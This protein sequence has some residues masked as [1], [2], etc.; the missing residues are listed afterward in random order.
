MSIPAA[1]RIFGYI[2]NW[3]YMVQPHNY[4]KVLIV[5]QLIT[6]LVLNLLH[7]TNNLGAVCAV[8]AIW[9]LCHTFS[10]TYSYAY[11]RTFSSLAFKDRAVVIVSLAFPLG[12]LGNG[13][14][15]MYF[16]YWKDTLLYYVGI[17]SLFISF[18][19]LLLYPGADVL[20]RNINS[21][22]R[23]SFKICL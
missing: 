3:F 16:G 15:S 19:L 7:F 13:I 2:F 21:R 8:M 14:F 23:V 12:G 6:G 4:F 22:Q 10:T 11:A 17:P 18:F 20:E 1:T 5:N 9:S